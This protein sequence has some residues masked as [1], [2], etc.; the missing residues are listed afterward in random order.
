MIE[1]S[2][3]RPLAVGSPT[4]LRPRVTRIGTVR[5]PV[6]ANDNPHPG[7]ARSGLFAL[8]IAAAV[9]AAIVAATLWL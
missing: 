6:A 9:G 8:I 3:P 7:G 1:R 4:K 5:V 2:S